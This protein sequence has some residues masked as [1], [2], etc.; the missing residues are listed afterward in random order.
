MLLDEQN[1]RSRLSVIREADTVP[2]SAAD[3]APLVRV[4]RSWDP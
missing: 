3:L 2:P 4:P 1:G